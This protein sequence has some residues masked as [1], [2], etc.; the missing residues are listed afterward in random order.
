[1]LRTLN[2]YMCGPCHRRI[3]SDAVRIVTELRAGESGVRVLVDLKV[4]VFL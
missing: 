3:P 2:T 1:M 4:V